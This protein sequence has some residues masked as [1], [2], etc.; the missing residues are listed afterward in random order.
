MLGIDYECP[1]LVPLSVEGG[2]TKWVLF[3]SINPGAPQGG[4]AVQYFVG[5]FDGRRFTPDDTATRFADFGKDFY[6]LQTYADA[7]GDSAVA[8]AWVSNWQYGEALPTGGWRGVMSLPRALSLRRA[9]ADWRLVQAFVALDPVRATAITVQTNS[10]SAG[11]LASVTLPIGAA[12]EVRAEIELDRDTV[13]TLCIG[14]AGGETLDIGFDQASAQVFVD[15]GGTRG[16][17]NRYFTDKFAAAVPYGTRAID[18]HLV[19]DICVLEF[20]GLRGV[21][22]GTFLCFFA[23]PPE[24]LAIEAVGSVRVR[25]LSITMLAAF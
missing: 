5:E 8:I 4:S 14:N 17:H 15:R 21:T 9:A 25:S 18:M 16:F 3:V 6:A 13:V 11:R 23:A 1:D 7:P 2:G 20:L 10:E 12:V 19:M 22:S 24:W